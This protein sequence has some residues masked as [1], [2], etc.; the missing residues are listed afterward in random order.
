MRSKK[1][2]NFL[3]DLFNMSLKE[4]DSSTNSKNDVPVWS[5]EVIKK[6]K[7]SAFNNCPKGQDYKEEE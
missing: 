2:A 6:P 3:K 1:M 7:D 5:E 4:D